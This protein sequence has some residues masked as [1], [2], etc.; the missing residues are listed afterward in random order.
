[1]RRVEDNDYQ[2]SNFGTPL[3]PT[4]GNVTPTIPTGYYASLEGLSGSV[5]KQAIQ[6]IIA[7]PAVVH[8]HS[9]ADIWD[10]IELPNQNQ[11]IIL[12]CGVCIL[13]SLCQKLI[14]N[15]AQAL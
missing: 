5:L 6:D 10:I 8:L 7:N 2:I 9:Y 15:K 12:K 3:A 4:Y 14:N 13:S 11:L 1:M